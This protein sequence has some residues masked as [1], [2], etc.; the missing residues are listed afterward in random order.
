MSRVKIIALLLALSLLTSCKS[1]APSS[2]IVPDGT[3]SATVTA[4]DN[5]PTEETEDGYLLAAA[6][7]NYSLYYEEKGLTVKVKNNLTGAVIDSAATPDEE[8]SEAWKNF[9]NSGIVLEY[10]KGTAVNLNK[11]N[12]YSGKPDTKISLIKDGFAAEVKFKSIGISLTVFVTLDDNGIRVRIP[13]SSIKEENE[14]YRLAAIYVLPFLGYTHLGDVEG[15]MLIPD[16]C[17]ALI[18]LKDNNQKF[19]QPYKAKIYGGNYSVESNNYAVQKYDDT[20]ATAAD[21]AGIFAPVFG[22]VHTSNQNA[23][24]GI[25]ESGKYNAEIYAYPNGVINEYNWITARYIYRETYKFL[26][27]QSGSITS[28][29]SDRETFDISVAYRFKGGADANYVGLAKSYRE[30]LLE[31]K[32]LNAEKDIGYDM[33]L[34]FFAGD[35]E[36]SLFG[37]KF[38][39]MTTIEQIDDILAELTEEGINNLSVSLKGWQKGGIYGDLTGKPSF[40]GAVGKLNDYAKLAGKYSNIDFLLYGDFLNTYKKAGSKDY[41]FQYNGKVFSD[42]TFL[43]L[44]TTKYRYT[45]DA[46]KRQINA[47]AKSL[48]DK[49]N[50]GISFDGVTNELYSY[51]SG[52][53]MKMFSRQYAAGVN[54]DTLSAA[55]EQFPTAYTAPNDYLWYSVQRYYDYKIYGSDY[56]FVTGEVP[57][58]AIV[59]K[60][61][62][63]LYSEYINFKADVTEYKLKLIESGIYPSFLLTS[64]SPSELIYTDSASLFSCQYSEYKETIKEYN[65]IFTK[66]YSLTAN[67]KIWDHTQSNGVAVTTYE[68]GAKVAVN[69]NK[70]A[71]QYDGNTIE[72]QSYLFIDGKAGQ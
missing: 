10:Y 20:I 42:D 5:K 22:M 59:L 15:Y 19:S 44:H 35:V 52:E 70:S 12:M 55:G 40:E 39:P 45:A 68:N 9:V 37:T 4:L 57:F 21:S 17:G 64:E 7:D 41:I 43:K 30:Y 13:S 1:R 60:G 66:L 62:V 58:F 63:P 65:E 47:L 51:E 3:M 23:F 33:R 69:Y 32:A 61:S 49:G 28:V 14:Q 29:Q 53:R 48:A 6:N 50:I 71:V 16:G 46:A 26:T 34:D 56:K 8:S 31:N 11:V 54:G 36:K 72:G 38:V 18:A 67:S 2:E 25:V 24:L 27:G